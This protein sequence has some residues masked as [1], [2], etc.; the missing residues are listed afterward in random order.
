M[1]LIAERK[2]DAGRPDPH[3]SSPPPKM[4][5]SQTRP[6]R[7]PPALALAGSMTCVASCDQPPSAL[8]HKIVVAVGALSPEQSQQLQ[9]FV[10]GWTEQ[11]A[12][13]RD[14][15]SMTDPRQ[16]L[17][18]PLRDLGGGPN[19]HRAFAAFARPKLE[20]II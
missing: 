6:P 2:A 15:K 3:L 7:S 16:S 13:A 11:L 1:G 18:D 10:E 17:T 19:F 20:A 9:A 14:P 12:E 5:I 4:T 8:D